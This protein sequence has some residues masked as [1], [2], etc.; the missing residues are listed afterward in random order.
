MYVNFTPHSGGLAKSVW[1]KTLHAKGC[2]QLAKIPPQ[3]SKSAD[4]KSYINSKI[5]V[6]KLIFIRKV[7]I[8]FVIYYSIFLQ[9]QKNKK[10]KKKIVNQEGYR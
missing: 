9:R 2:C 1:T 3:H 5:F 4:T 8:I 7:F 6:Q 10:K